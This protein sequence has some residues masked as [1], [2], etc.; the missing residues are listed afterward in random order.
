MGGEHGSVDEVRLLLGEQPLEPEQ[1]R[2]LAPPLERRLHVSLVD[3]GDGGVERAAASRTGRKRSLGG[4][5]VVYELLVRQPLGA[6]D[7]G[8]TGKR[9]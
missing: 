6:C 4:F 9:A 7:R 8:I 2:E 5:T 1:Q 3:L